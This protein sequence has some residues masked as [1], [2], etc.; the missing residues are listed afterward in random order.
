MRKL[1]FTTGSPF[2]RAVR[3]VLAEKGLEYDRDEMITTTATEVR[4]ADTPTLQVPTL[5][6][7]KGSR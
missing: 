1:Y 6:E 2:A 5:A 4:E 7:W 3:I